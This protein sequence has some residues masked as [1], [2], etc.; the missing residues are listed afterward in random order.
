MT[1]TVTQGVMNT[2]TVYK[3]LKKDN[4]FMNKPYAVKISVLIE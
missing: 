2:K 4:L 3:P 1:A